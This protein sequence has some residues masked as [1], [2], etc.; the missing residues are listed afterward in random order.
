[1][2]VGTLTTEEEDVIIVL[3]FTFLKLF[4]TYTFVVSVVY[5]V[6][7]SRDSS[8][9]IATCYGQDGPGIESRGGGE[10]FR[11]CPDRPWG[12]PS[13]LYNGYRVPFPGLKRPGRGVEYPP[14]LA[15]KL[16]KD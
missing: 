9:S 15:P 13:L 4:M 11:T 14:Y 8:V 12:P 5:I 1:M 7:M 3:T 6:Y 16:K 2:A 10:V